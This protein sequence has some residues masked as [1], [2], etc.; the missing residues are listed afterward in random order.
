MPESILLNGNLSSPFKPGHV[1]RV[2]TCSVL[3]TT[4]TCAAIVLVGGTTVKIK[5]V[6]NLLIAAPVGRFA[7]FQC[8]N[9]T[10]Y[11]ASCASA[12]LYFASAPADRRTTTEIC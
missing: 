11:D 12:T 8:Q 10:T 5:G 2:A 7:Q 9:C 6:K 1:K 3:H 4:N